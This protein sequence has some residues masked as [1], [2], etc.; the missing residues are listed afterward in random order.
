MKIYP[1]YYAFTAFNRLYKLGDEIAI[2][3]DAD[4]VYGCGASDGKWACAVIANPTATSRPVSLLSDVEP[5][6]FVVTDKLGVDRECY[7]LD[8]IP[9]ESIVSIYFDLR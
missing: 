9:G 6:R 1:A 3:L 8:A 5:H 2:Y 7:T 4:D